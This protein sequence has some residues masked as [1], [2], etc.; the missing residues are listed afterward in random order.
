M[1]FF[2]F[3]F[4][5]TL[6][7]SFPYPSITLEQPNQLNNFDLQMFT[8]PRKQRAIKPGISSEDLI[9]LD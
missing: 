6:T 5:M 2:L 8:P 3:F 9:V 4:L 7:D 1:F